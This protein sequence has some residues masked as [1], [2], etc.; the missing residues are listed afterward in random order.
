MELWLWVLTT[1]GTPVLAQPCKLLGAADSG[2]AAPDSS[3]QAEVNP[4]AHGRRRLCGFA[5]LGTMVFVGIGAAGTAAGFSPDR[6]PDRVWCLELRDALESGEPRLVEPSWLPLYTGAVAALGTRGEDDH[7]DLLIH[8]GPGQPV[9]A[10]RR[11]GAYRTQ[12]AFLAGP[13]SGYR[14]RVT[15]WQRVRMSGDLPAGCHVQFFTL[16]RNEAAF[17][18]TPPVRPQP[19][20]LP[21]W[22]RAEK[23]GD[24]FSR[25]GFGPGTEAETAGPAV[26]E[27]N[28]LY[29]AGEL[30]PRPDPRRTAPESWYAAAEGQLDFLVGNSGGSVKEPADQFWIFGLMAGDGTRSPRLVQ[31]RLAY[32]E[33]G[34][35]ADLP[36]VYRRD[37]RGREFLGPMLA[38]FE[39][40]FEDLTE[41]VDRLPGLFSPHVIAGLYGHDSTEVRW[42]AGALALA[43]PPPPVPRG[44]AVALF[45]DGPYWLSRRGTPSGLRRLVWLETGVEVHVDEP[46]V[47]DEPWVAGEAAAG[48]GAALAP[49]RPDGTVLGR[50]VLGQAALGDPTGRTLALAADL[51][52]HF[53]IRGYAADLADAD[54]RRAVEAAVLRAA[55]AHATYSVQ[56][57]EPRLRVGVQ[58][59]LGIDAV[60]AAHRP[61]DPFTLG[62]PPGPDTQLSPT[63]TTSPTVGEAVLGSGTTLQ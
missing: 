31:G 19:Y 14:D 1:E 54:T 9:V 63:P 55:P 41:M 23:V 42:L 37:N 35:L 22:F 10:L 50:D 51:A 27:R 29:K 2:P 17:L 57:I 3:A 52:H 38:L 48:E 13:F 12:G 21:A 28:P 4:L 20:R 49:A 18:W 56:V 44:R 61:A 30:G 6:E 58:A 7:A 15:P 5:A 8:P 33:D 53:V 47:A 59:R 62:P 25:L 16:S 34:W 43:L 40:A 60:V 36:A 39:S 46:G 24:L 26:V 11:G 45:A 32:D